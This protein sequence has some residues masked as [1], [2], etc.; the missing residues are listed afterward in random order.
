MRLRAS[1]AALVALVLVTVAPQ[2]NGGGGTPITTCGQVV[3]TNA[4]LT[5]DLACGSRGIIAGA[6]GITIDLKGFMV[7]GSPAEGSY[8]LLSPGFDKVTFKNGVVRNFDIGVFASGADDFAVT[9]VVATG[10]NTG[11]TIFGDSGTV[12]TS[13]AAAA[14]NLG[15]GIY[16]I[17]DDAK[18]QSSTVSANFDGLRIVGANARVQSSTVSG[19]ASVGIAVTGD[20]AVLKSNR[21]EGNGFGSGLFATS[22]LD[23]TGILVAGY[24]TAPTGKNIARGN[25]N[26]NE[27]DPTNLCH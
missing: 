9:D 6:S 3:T 25:D 2:A 21:A 7:F 16:I 26:P 8:G 10:N 18:V 5:G 24:T 12:K 19:N 13:T 22:D 4:F 14:L 15:R 11:I 23:G 27:C 20:A 1:L 17:G